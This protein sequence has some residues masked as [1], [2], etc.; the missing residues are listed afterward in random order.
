MTAIA[1]L[2][3]ETIVTRLEE[4]TTANGYE[5][6]VAE[7]VRPDRTGEVTKYKHLGLF[8]EQGPRLRVPA[9]D[10]ASSTPK[11]AYQ[12][13][14][15]IKCNARPSDTSARSTW[16]N[17][18]YDA[19]VKAVTDASN[20]QTMGGNAV[21]SEIGD[22]ESFEPDEGEMVGCTVHVLVYYRV[23]ESNPSAL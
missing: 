11:I 13:N 14:V 15:Q 2:I 20:W 3:L 6:D 12:M 16:E 1:E 18:M 22:C 21:Y 23:Q 7:V 9:M 5:F 17:K 4:I 19:V 8:V 10:V